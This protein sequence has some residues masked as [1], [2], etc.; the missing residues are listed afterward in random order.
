MFLDVGCGL[1]AL[2]ASMASAGARV[3]GID[4]QVHLLEQARLACPSG[5]FF[6]I[7]LHEFIAEEPFDGIL[8]HAVLHWTGDP[9]A[10]FRKLWS[11]LRPGGRIAASFGA[12]AAEAANLINYYLPDAGECARTLERIGFQSIRT[13]HWTQ[14]VLVYAERPQQQHAPETD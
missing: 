8:A 10:A 13:E 7:G 5:R 4:P 6:A 14:G 9:E 3:T 2:S 12:R 1:G 11:L